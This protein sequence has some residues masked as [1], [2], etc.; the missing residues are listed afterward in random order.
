MLDGLLILNTLNARSKIYHL[1]EEMLV[2]KRKWSAITSLLPKRI[3]D[4]SEKQNAQT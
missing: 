1:N 2:L 4:T 3:N